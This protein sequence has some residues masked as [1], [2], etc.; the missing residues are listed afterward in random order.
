MKHD[1]AVQLRCMN[2][3]KWADFTKQT[4]WQLN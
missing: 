1:S 3:T 4:N 2:R